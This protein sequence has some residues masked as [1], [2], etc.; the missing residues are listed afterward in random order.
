MENKTILI[1][2]DEKSNFRFLEVLLKRTR[3]KIIRA[4]NGLEAIS[5]FKNNSIDLILMDIK[6]PVM[7]G[8]EATREIKKL[9]RDIPIIALTAFAMQNDTNICKDA[10]CNDYVAKPVSQDKLFLVLKKYL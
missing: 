4:I 7:D 1:A 2:E 3:A 5:I 9:N 8:L 6:M 10:G